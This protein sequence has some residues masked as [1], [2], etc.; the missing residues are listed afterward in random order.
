MRYILYGRAT[1]HFKGYYK[2]TD[3]ILNTLD[4]SVK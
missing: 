1:Q 2:V 3:C 4:S